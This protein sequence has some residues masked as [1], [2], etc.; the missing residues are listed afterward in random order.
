MSQVFTMTT[1]FTKFHDNYEKIINVWESNLKESDCWWCCHAFDCDPLPTVTR[2]TALGNFQVKG[3]FCSWNCSKAYA[4]A[5]QLDPPGVNL[6]YRRMTGSKG[7]V[8]AA[9]P[10]ESLS[11]FGGPFDIV[12]F[13]KLFNNSWKVEVVEPPMTKLV[14][15]IVMSE[16]I[17]YRPSKLVDLSHLVAP[18]EQVRVP[19]TDKTVNNVSVRARKK[20][21]VTREKNGIGTKT[22]T[23]E[24]L[25]YHN[26][27][28]RKT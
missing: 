9:G 28:A 15:S 8:A 2:F 3:S 21:P 20:K 13:R 5:N 14:T 22:V 17:E 25:K 4:R 26:N 7:V 16:C 11:K 10:R 18:K 24:S 1:E 12:E 6:L 19:Y 27:K 23:I